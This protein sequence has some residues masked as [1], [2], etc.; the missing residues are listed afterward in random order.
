MTTKVNV[1]VMQSQAK[2]FQ[3]HSKGYKMQKMNL[4]FIPPEG[5]Q[6]YSHLNS[7]PVK[8]TRPRNLWE[9]KFL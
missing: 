2:K 5:A 9:N 1:E 4:S 3:Q 8:L 6:P 7:G